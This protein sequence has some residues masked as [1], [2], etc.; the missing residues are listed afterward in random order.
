MII[1]M[2]FKCSLENKR[3]SYAIPDSCGLILYILGG[4]FFWRAD[5]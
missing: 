1:R 5:L 4:T 3:V 2:D